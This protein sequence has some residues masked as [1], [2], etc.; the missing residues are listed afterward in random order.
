MVQVR[1]QLT[2]A[3]PPLI[4]FSPKGSSHY[5][6]SQSSVQQLPSSSSVQG[7]SADSPVGQP[8][9]VIFL[10]AQILRCQGCRGKI[11]Q[12]QASPEGVVLQHKEYVLFQNP[13]TGSWQMSK[14]MRNTY[15]HPQLNCVSRTHPG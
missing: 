2:P 13:R 9:C 1:V 6:P 14:N 11:E 4:H 5:T 12:G 15:Y 3:P 8:F 10:N 7:M